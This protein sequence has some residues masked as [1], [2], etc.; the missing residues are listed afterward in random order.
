MVI[1][2][3]SWS[4]HKKCAKSCTQA[5]SPDK[6]CEDYGLVL[7]SGQGAGPEGAGEEKNENPDIFASIFEGR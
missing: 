5:E 1:L 7:P 2:N 4:L 6:I 3:T